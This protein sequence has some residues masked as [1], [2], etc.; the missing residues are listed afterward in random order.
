M[1]KRKHVA[2]LAV[3]ACSALLS[4]EGGQGLEGDAASDGADSEVDSDVD[5]L[6]FTEET[7]DPCTDSGVPES[8]S[9]AEHCDGIVIEG[10]MILWHVPEGD[11]VCAGKEDCFTRANETP[12]FDC[13]NLCSCLCLCEACYLVDCTLVDC[14]G[15]T[16]YR[17]R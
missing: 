8:I 10:E 2:T 9:V 17:Y 3:F 6:D 7:A 4:C 15:D 13:P 1:N 11:H 5:V 16:S 12:D 14:G